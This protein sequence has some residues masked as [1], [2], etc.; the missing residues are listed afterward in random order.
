M[1]FWKQYDPLHLI[2][3]W[4]FALC[5]RMA[6]CLHELA[7]ESRQPAERN[8]RFPRPCGERC[9]DS[10]RFSS[11]DEFLPRGS[12]MELIPF[13]SGTYE[14]DHRSE[15]DLVRR[16]PNQVFLANL[17]RGHRPP[18][19]MRRR[20]SLQR[21]LVEAPSFVLQQLLQLL[22]QRVDVALM[23]QR[24]SQSQPID[25]LRAHA[26]LSYPCRAKSADRSAIEQGMHDDLRAS[27]RF[28][29]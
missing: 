5:D 25:R 13:A 2:P 20:L 9:I 14:L 24:G 22:H 19:R 10:S 1:E 6:K 27:S 16:L 28:R 23:G 7:A 8:I 17:H 26:E 4:K 15:R 18:L 29:R 21:H 3:Q 11:Q 12:A